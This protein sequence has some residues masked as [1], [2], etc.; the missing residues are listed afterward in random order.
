[1]EK[2]NISK[3][4]LE[5]IKALYSGTKCSVLASNEMSQTF[6]TTIGVR[7][8]CSLSPCMFNLFLKHI[9][10]EALENYEGMVS[11]DGRKVYNLLF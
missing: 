4:I 2:C 11:I 5:T 10:S 1:M 7:Q 6:S 9:M 8:G 3:Q